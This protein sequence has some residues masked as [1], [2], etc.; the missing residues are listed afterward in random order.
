MGVRQGLHGGR[1][2]GRHAGPYRRPRLQ[3]RHPRQA[4]LTRGP[5]GC[6]ARP[7]PKARQS[8]PA[9]SAA[10]RN[11]N[12]L[13]GGIPR[14]LL[15][16][17]LA[18]RACPARPPGKVDRRRVGRSTLRLLLGQSSSVK[19]LQ[20]RQ[21]AP[22]ARGLCCPPAGRL[23]RL[24]TCKVGWGEFGWGGGGGGR[25]RWQAVKLSLASLATSKV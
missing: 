21:G 12:S 8:R 5:A 20:R 3:E 19:I 7:G 13:V 6:T 14:E 1:H 4:R 22:T 11:S 10:A 23:C 25:F 24:A 18:A 17:V 2:P 9:A 15:F 16:I